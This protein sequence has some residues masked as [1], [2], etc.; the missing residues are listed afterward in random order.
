VSDAGRGRTR[1]RETLVA[2]TLARTIFTS[3]M[4]GYGGHTSI[5]TFFGSISFV[6]S[7]NSDAS[8]TA[9]CSS[10][11][12]FQFPA[13]NGKRPPPTIDSA[14]RA[15]RADQVGAHENAF[16]APTTTNSTAT[17]RA[18]IKIRLVCGGRSR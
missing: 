14:L 9:D 12:I 18:N 15:D 16:A 13:M 10:V 7:A 5:S 4:N 11:F 3:R 1:Q 6:K 8:A 17:T 2:F